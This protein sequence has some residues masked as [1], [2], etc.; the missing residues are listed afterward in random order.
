M[1]GVELVAADKCSST[2]VVVAA[3]QM[4]TPFID[5]LEHA[6]TVLTPTIFQSAESQGSS[7]NALN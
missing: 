1:S 6:H 4:C 3:T 2:A 5:P 7:T